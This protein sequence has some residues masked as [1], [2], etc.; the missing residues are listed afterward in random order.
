MKLFLPKQHGAW[1]MLIIP[2]WL[3]V[4]A[5]EFMWQHIPFFI[6][7]TLMY[8]GTYPFLLIFKGKKVPFH[9]KWTLFYM[10]P[11]LLLLLIPLFAR[12]SII[13]FGLLMLPLFSLNIYFSYTNNDRALMNDFLAIFIFSITGL[14]SSYLA[15]GG[16]EEI[17]IKL[18]MLNFLFFAGCTFYVKTMIR[19]KKSE[20]YKWISFS[21]HVLVPLILLA[22]RQWI[23]AAALLPSLI[24]AFYLYGKS[25]SIKKIGII[26]IVNAAIFFI[27]ILTGL[28]TVV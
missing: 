5:S 7:W 17:D 13:W 1:A 8:L 2:Y 23:A 16:I 10:V 21:Y 25:Y 20:V 26:E 11:G 24:R 27:L 3:G 19:E 12:P 14:A 18:F 15:K 4:A 22:D 28:L 6:G 9:T